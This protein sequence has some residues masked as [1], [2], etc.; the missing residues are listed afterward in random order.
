MKYLFEDHASFFFTSTRRAFP[1][2]P[3]DSTLGEPTDLISEESDK[4]AS[5]SKSQALS[6][7]SFPILLLLCFSTSPG[8]QGCET[9][10]TTV[11]ILPCCGNGN[12]L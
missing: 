9:L 3:L 7:T 10:S 1:R 5:T 11:T 2:Q 12:L 6:Q 8:V 4:G